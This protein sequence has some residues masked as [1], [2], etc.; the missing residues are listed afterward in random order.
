MSRNIS[1]LSLFF[2]RTQMAELEF[3]ISS[4]KERVL[5]AQARLGLDPNFNLTW[6][7]VS[8]TC[9]TLDIPRSLK[10]TSHFVGAHNV[11]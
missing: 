10:L 2:I 5:L 11:V 7:Q 9:R 6:T 8:T 3:S 1:Q 4:E